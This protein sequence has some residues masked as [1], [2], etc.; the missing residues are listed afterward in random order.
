MPGLD[1]NERRKKA[2]AQVIIHLLI[3][4]HLEAGTSSWV[5]TTHPKE[6]GESDVAEAVLGKAR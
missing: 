2:L 1:T 6:W 5:T 4:A 3:K